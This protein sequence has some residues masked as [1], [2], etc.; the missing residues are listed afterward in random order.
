MSQRF[1]L[2]PGGDVPE[3]VAAR[4]VALTVHEFREKLPALV[5]RGF[6][7]PDPTTGKFDLDAIDVWRKARYPRLFPSDRLLLGPVARDA[8]DVVSDRL[9]NRGSG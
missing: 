2:P 8:K 4:R 1:K 6:P 5:G 7:T 3:D 9:R